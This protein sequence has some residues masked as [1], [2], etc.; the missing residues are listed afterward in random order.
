VLDPGQQQTFTVRVRPGRPVHLEC[1]LAGHEAAGMHAT[2][3]VAQG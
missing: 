2:V 3:A 1:T